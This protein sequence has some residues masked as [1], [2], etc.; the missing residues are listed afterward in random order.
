M[1]YRCGRVGGRVTGP[2]ETLAALRAVGGHVEVV[3]PL[4][5]DDI[6]LQAVHPLIGAGKAPRRFQVAREV[7][8]GK[9]NLLSFFQSVKADIAEAVE[10][11]M[12]PQDLFLSV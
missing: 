11:K 9:F 1:K 6:L 12:R 8:G 7:A 10:S 3:V 2:A 5:P 4:S